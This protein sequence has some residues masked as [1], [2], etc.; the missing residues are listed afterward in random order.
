M[1]FDLGAEI[2]EE[3]TFEADPEVRRNA[4]FLSLMDD[5]EHAAA[6]TFLTGDDEDG[7]QKGIDLGFCYDKDGMYAIHLC[8]INNEYVPTVCVVGVETDEGA[9]CPVFN[10]SCN[11]SST[12]GHQTSTPV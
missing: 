4:T 5:G 11:T 7:H 10:S 1:N 8:A 9:V 2:E 12:R 6:E 3:M